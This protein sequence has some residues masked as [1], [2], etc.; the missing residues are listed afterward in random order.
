[1]IETEIKDTDKTLFENQKPHKKMNG[2]KFFAMIASIIFAICCVGAVHQLTNSVSAT[3][4]INSALSAEGKNPDG[5]PFSIME[6]FNDDIMN[7][8]AQKLD[9]KMSAQEIRSHLNISDAM[10]VQSFAQVEQ[11]ILDGEN[12]NIY[13]PTEYSITYSV[14]SEQIQNEGFLSQ[15]KS[16]WK[17]F[18]LPSKSEILNAVLESYQEYYAETYLN[19]EDLFHIDWSVVDSMDHYNRYEFMND[20]VVR[21][22]NFL[23]YKDANSILQSETEMNT[24]YD[25]MVAEFYQGIYRSVQDYQAYVIQYGVTNDKA[26]LFRQFTYMQKYCLEENTRKLQEYDVLKKAIDLYDTSTSQI[27]YIPA[28]DATGSFYMNKTKTGL[29]YLSEKADSMKLQADSALHAAEQ[30]FYLQT[31]FGSEFITD[32]NGERIQVKNTLEQRAYADELYEALKTRIQ[33]LST[34]LELMLTEDHQQSNEAILIGKPASG[35]GIVGVAMGFAKRFALLS[36][37]A[38]MTIYVIRGV[39]EIKEKRMQGAEE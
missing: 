6:L 22:I 27:L 23:Q 31:C 26:T 32:A 36:M 2:V 1:M 13:F 20:T 29:D 37:A 10:T 17:R 9:G 21:F 12:E 15:C 28:L 5:T 38:Y 25:A 18:S 16:F 14:I 24:G 33:G 3:I 30:Y 19:Y 8:A 35:I 11:S 7:A 34:E 39:C 4:A